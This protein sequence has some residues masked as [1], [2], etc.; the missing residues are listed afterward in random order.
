MT[1]E[2]RTHALRAIGEY[3]D[4]MGTACVCER[5]QAIGKVVMG[6]D[7]GQAYADWPSALHGGYSVGR[8]VHLGYGTARVGG[9]D[10]PGPRDEALPFA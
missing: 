7:G 6:D 3:L 9:Q 10:L 8:L 2:L 1:L 5:V 4:R